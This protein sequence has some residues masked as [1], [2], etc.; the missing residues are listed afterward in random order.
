MQ[1]ILMDDA[2]DIERVLWNFP[3]THPCV[4]MKKKLKDVAFEKRSSTFAKSYK[5]ISSLSIYIYFV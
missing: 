2:K 1:S 4:A 3:P 5:K